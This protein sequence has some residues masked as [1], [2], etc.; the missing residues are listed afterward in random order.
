MAPRI[1]LVTP[2]TIAFSGDFLKPTLTSLTLTNPSAR[3]V[4]FRIKTTTPHRF[5]VKPHKGSIDAGAS[6]VVGIT[7]NPFHFDANEKYRDKFLL[8]VGLTF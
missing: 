8:L 1:E 3:A 2:D 4:R 6:A 7:S 5:V